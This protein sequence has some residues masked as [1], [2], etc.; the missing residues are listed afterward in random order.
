VGAIRI[1]RVWSTVE[2]ASEVAEAFARAAARPDPRDPRIAILRDAGDLPPQRREKRLVSR[3][4][5]T[6]PRG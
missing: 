5:R 1:G 2:V 6:P 4:P 3:A